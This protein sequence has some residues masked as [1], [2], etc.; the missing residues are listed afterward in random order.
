MRSVREEYAD[1]IRGLLGNETPD[2]NYLRRLLDVP[3]L[4]DRLI[5]H[6]QKH[7]M[8]VFKRFLAESPYEF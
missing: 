8:D 3:E 2:K 7:D 5:Y 6:A 1:T 4:C